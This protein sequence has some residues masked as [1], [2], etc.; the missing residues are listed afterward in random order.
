MFWNLVVMLNWSASIV[1]A[2]FMM[3]SVSQF[4][5]SRIALLAM[6]SVTRPLFI[7][8]RGLL[9][10]IE[11]DSLPSTV[12]VVLLPASSFFLWD[13]RHFNIRSWAAWFLSHGLPSFYTSF[14]TSC[15]LSHFTLK[16]WYMYEETPWD[17]RHRETSR[18]AI[19]Y[20]AHHGVTPQYTMRHIMRTFVTSWDK[21]QYWVLKLCM[22]AEQQ[23]FVSK[24]CKCHKVESQ[25]GRFW[26]MSGTIYH[27]S[28][29]IVSSY[30][31]SCIVYL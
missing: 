14:Y 20:M 29:I 28:D 16:W 10:L 6:L 4:D 17:V 8:G 3:S 31:T 12:M 22:V 25:N 18:D 27:V 9:L 26:G 2:A 19:N 11:P 13:H 23:K 24:Q 1:W 21:T 15:I 30:H 7:H 5:P